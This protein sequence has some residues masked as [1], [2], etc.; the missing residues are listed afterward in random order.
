M[1]LLD[2][3]PFERPPSKRLYRTSPKH[4]N[5]RQQ[6]YSTYERLRQ[7]RRKLDAL[8]YGLDMDGIRHDDSYSMHSEATDF[9]DR[10]SLMSAASYLQGASSCGGNPLCCC[11]WVQQ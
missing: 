9:G 1:H 5:N 6:L 7:R 8:R 3:G 11:G 10:K 2:D 4:P